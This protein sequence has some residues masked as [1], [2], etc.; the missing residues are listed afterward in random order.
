MT[1]LIIQLKG[2]VQSSNF[3]EWKNELIARLRG[4]N[5]E[6]ARDEDFVTAADQVKALKN[7]ESTLKEAKQSAIAQAADIQRL[8][9][10]IDVV[11]EETR[12]VR[13]ALERQIKA[14]KQEIKEQMIER[15]INTVHAAIVAELGFS[16]S[17][18]WEIPR[19]GTLRGSRQRQE[20]QLHSGQG[21]RKPGS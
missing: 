19:S 12:Q 11:V 1:D 4:V 7:A 18:P 16:I 21:A 13:L 17:G 6:L 14:R 2:E 8:F 20:H 10:S 3:E 9:G 5:T 15:A